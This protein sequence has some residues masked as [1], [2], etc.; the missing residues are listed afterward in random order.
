M[1]KMAADF[2]HWPKQRTKYDITQ[3]VVESG[4]DYPPGVCWIELPFE[5]WASNNKKSIYRRTR[6]EALIGW[7]GNSNSYRIYNIRNND[8]PK[9]AAPPTNPFSTPN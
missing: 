8:L 1:Q 3:I 4:P 7:E 5:W 2:K 9:E 6:L